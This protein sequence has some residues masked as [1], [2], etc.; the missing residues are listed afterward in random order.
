MTTQLQ[1]PINSGSNLELL[2]SR[3]FYLRTFR[4]RSLLSV[5]SF[6][7]LFSLPALSQSL[8]HMFRCPEL[9]M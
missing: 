3:A 9:Q 8:V 7:L 2:D 5:Y 1:S 6:P 4:G